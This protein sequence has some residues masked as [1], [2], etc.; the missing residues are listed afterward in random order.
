MPSHRRAASSPWGAGV[1]TGPKKAICSPSA[2][3]TAM[4]GV[5]TSWPTFSMPS[6]WEARSSGSYG[7]AS[8]WSMRDSGS[9]TSRSAAATVAFSGPS[10]WLWMR[11]PS[12][13]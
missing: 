3:G 9:P 12:A 8:Q 4:T 11:V 7:V 13:V 5:P 10:P 1:T 2:P 6:L